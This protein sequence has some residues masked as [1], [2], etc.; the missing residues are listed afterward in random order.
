MRMPISLGKPSSLKLDDGTCRGVPGG[1]QRGLKEVKF[2][3]P[4]GA[5]GLASRRRFIERVVRASEEDMMYMRCGKKER[6]EKLH[7]PAR[8]PWRAE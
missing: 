8:R 2:S 7:V 1:E 6:F 5:L 4:E 3:E